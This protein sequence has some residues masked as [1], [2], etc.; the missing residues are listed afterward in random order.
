MKLSKTWSTQ[1]IYCNVSYKFFFFFFFVFPVR[2]NIIIF[3]ELYNFCIFKSFLKYQCRFLLL[4]L[5]GVFS[6]TINR[7]Q[8]HIPEH[9]QLL[10]SLLTKGRPFG[11]FD[12]GEMSFSLVFQVH[13]SIQGGTQ[14]H[15]MRCQSLFVQ[16]LD[17]VQFH[18]SFPS[19]N[20]FIIGRSIPI[21]THYNRSFLK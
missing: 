3:V 15:L 7:L 2:F 21:W 19:I 4:Q 8:S 10:I 14:R 12:H 13:N 1:K 20:K 17:G 16:D 6:P 11:K 18:P 9:V 5:Q